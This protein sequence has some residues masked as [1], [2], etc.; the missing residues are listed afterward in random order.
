MREIP[1]AAFKN[2]IS[3]LVDAVEA[4]EEMVIT[5]HGRPA[6]R[7]GPMVDDQALRDQRRQAVERLAAFRQRHARAISAEEWIALRN[8]D[9]A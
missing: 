2:R 9:R 1:I 3:E 6:A 7:V 5:R 8:E 4:G